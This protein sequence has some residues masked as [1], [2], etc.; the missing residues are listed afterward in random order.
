MVKTLTW[1]PAPAGPAAAATNGAPKAISSPAAGRGPPY[2]LSLS[3]TCSD[4]FEANTGVEVD[5]AD[6]LLLQECIRYAV[7]R[8]LGVHGALRLPRAEE[9]EF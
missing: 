6:W 8:L 4:G 3:L 7:P 9:F 1:S 2:A 5:A